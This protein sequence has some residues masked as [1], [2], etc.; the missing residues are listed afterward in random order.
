[1]AQVA[2]ELRKPSTDLAASFER[3]RDAVLGA[4]EEGW[5]PHGTGIALTDVHAYIRAANGWAKGEGVPED[6]VPMS[7]YWI[8]ESGEVVGEL[9]I[10]HY[11]TP[12]LRE[13][14]G[15]IGYHTHPDHRGKGVATFALR[16][17]LKVLAGMGVSSAL[18][19]CSESNVASLRVIEKCG[20]VRVQDSII[21]GFERRYRLRHFACR[22]T[23]SRPSTGVAKSVEQALRASDRRPTHAR[24][25]FSAQGVVE[26][27]LDDPDQDCVSLT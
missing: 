7:I 25:V 1:V 5:G 4:G 8:V 22:V 3:M 13:M 19:T 26:S 24:T 18:I 27:T 21:P 15:H 6:W 17:G 10:R 11:L 2:F 12:K 23:L 16:E 14:G 20:G 9:D